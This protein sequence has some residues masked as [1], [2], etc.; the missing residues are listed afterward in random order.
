M[1]I[2]ISLMTRPP[3]FLR[4]AVQILYEEIIPFLD[5]G[6]IGNMLAVIGTP[7]GEFIEEI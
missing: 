4:K 1:D 5:A 7:D 6:D 3:A 2:F